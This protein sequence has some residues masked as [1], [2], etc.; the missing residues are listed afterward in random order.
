MEVATGLSAHVWYVALDTTRADPPFDNK[1]VRQAM[2][3]AVNK[4]AIVKDI[5]KGT[6]EVSISPLSPIYGDSYNPDVQKYPYDP[7]KAKSLFGR[8]RVSRRV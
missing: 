7:E 2:N 3:Y 5:V 8:G 6:G 1:L 4:E